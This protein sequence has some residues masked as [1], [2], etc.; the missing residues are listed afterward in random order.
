MRGVHRVAEQDNVLMIHAPHFDQREI[1]P[2]HKIIREQRLA[3]EII[4]ENI[5]QILARLR[6]RHFFKAG[7]QPRL[8]W[9]FDNEGAVLFAEGI[10]VRDKESGV[11]LFEDHRQA[12]KGLL[13]AEP[14]KFI[15]PHFNRRHEE[16]LK[17]FAN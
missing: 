9:A 11:G 1:D 7:F 12:V 16:R 6:V 3:A 17:S 8:G 15:L 14:N 10:R 13:G 4:F 2:L 5:R